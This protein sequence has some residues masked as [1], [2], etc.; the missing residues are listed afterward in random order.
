MTHHL[1]TFGIAARVS[2]ITAVM[3]SSSPVAPRAQSSQ[4]SRGA[5]R[6][7]TDS[8]PGPPRGL[9]RL[10]YT[11]PPS[12][13][14]ARPSYQEVAED[15]KQLQLRNYNLSQAASRGAPLD[16][17]RIRTEAAE[18]KK[19]ASRLRKY[20]LLPQPND[21]L[22]TDEGEGIVSPEGLTAAAASL[23]A[24]V[25]SFVWNPVFQQPGV[26]NLELSSK[27]SRDLEAIIR[28]SEQIRRSAENFGKGASKN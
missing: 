21:D 8:S 9:E 17:A 11:P 14:R 19:R 10:V 20:L 27:A 18:V 6:I 1:R 16:Y 24:L 26:I 7:E 15:F 5:R 28:L 12:P 2:L 23:D 25:N 4:S 22:K 13:R 3:Y